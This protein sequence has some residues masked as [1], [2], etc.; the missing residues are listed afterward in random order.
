MI[1]GLHA[2]YGAG[3]GRNGIT[4]AAAD[5]MPDHAAGD[6]ADERA[7]ATGPAFALNI[8]DA[9][10]DAVLNR[11]IRGVAALTIVDGTASRDRGC[12][13]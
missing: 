2:A 8:I 6:R 1:R 11:V 13:R 5:L 10:D 3:D 7:G 9:F 12:D 4:R